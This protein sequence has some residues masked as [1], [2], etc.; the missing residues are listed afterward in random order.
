MKYLNAFNKIAGVGPKK[1]KLLLNHFSTFEDAWQAGLE[2]L[3]K[4]QIGEKISETIIRERKNISP[5]AE[6]E[7]LK[8]ENIRMV[9]FLDKTY[10]NLLKEIFN[11]PFVLYIKGGFDFNLYP[12]VAIVGS[13]KFTDYGK[14]VAATFAKDLVSAGITV[15]SGMAFGIDSFAHHSALDAGGK[16][17]AVLGNSLDDKNIYPASHLGLSKEIIRQGALVSEYPLETMAGKLTFP[18]RNRII[19][20]LSLGVIVVEAQE[21][22]GA[23]ITAQ[24]ALEYNREIFSVP[25]SVFSPFSAGTHNLLRSG[26]KIVT[27]IKDVLEEL[28]L[29]KNFPSVSKI[30]SHSDASPEEE[31]VLSVLS[32]DPLHIDNISRLAKLQTNIISSCLAMMEIKGWI[33]NIGGQNYIKL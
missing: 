18:A 12:A 31:T 19:A 28:N 33:K 4:S 27:G 1:L 25:G 24:A 13:R 8:K 17:V 26:A 22:S 29:E 32:S 7:K 2:E 21:K 3:K 14:Q 6:W 10:P 30:I 23:L 20:G 5:N 11:P 15:I 16:T 9:T